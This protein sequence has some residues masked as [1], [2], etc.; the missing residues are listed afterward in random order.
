MSS[1]SSVQS[2]GLLRALLV[3][4]VI[5]FGFWLLNERNLL[6]IVL[7]GDKSHIS[8]IIGFLWIITSLYWILLSKNISNEK[9]SL[10]N[11]NFHNENLSTTKFFN[12]LEGGERKEI[13]LNAIE[14][15][16]E[17][18]LSY[19]M[20]ASE[21]SLKLGLLGTIIGFILMLQPIANLDNTSPENLKIALA[22]MSSGMAVALYTTLSGIVVNTLLRIQFHISSISITTLLNDLAFY[23]EDNIE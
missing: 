2:I 8:K 4:V 1:K 10:S 22:S 16:F 5:I 7:E 11:F 17:K 18:K 21:I 6:L 3:L 13:L 19:G 12:G 9:D 15:D 14:L 23:T 20:I